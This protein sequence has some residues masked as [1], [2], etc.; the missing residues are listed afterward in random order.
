MPYLTRGNRVI[1]VIYVMLI[2]AARSAAA[3]DSTNVLVVVNELSPE[4]QEIASYYA[5]VR[6]IPAENVVRV[7]TAVADEIERRRY[8]LDIEVPILNHITSSSAHDR[9]LYLVLTKGIPLRVRGTTGLN[10]SVAS[11]DSEL[12]L[13]YQRLLGVRVLPAGRFPNPYFT[14]GDRPGQHVA[15]FSHE[16]HGIYL[17]TRLDGYTVADVKQ[18]IDRAAAPQ[19]EGLFVLDQ[20]SELRRSVGNTWLQQAAERLSAT[21][22]SKHV[23]FESTAAVAEV[24]KPVLGYFSWGSNDP[25]VKTRQSR[26]GFAP[27]ALAGTFV[28]TDARTF[29][30]PPANWAIGRW[31]DRSTFFE[32]SP[33]SLTGDLIRE[34]ATGVSGHVAEPYLDATV[35][36]HIL[37]PAYASGLNLA[38]SFYLGIPYLSWQNVVIGDPLCAPFRTKSLSTAEATPPLDPDTELP[39]YFS[40]KRIG[41][42][43]SLGVRS[44]VARLMLKASA[45]VARGDLGLATRSLEEVTELEPTLNAAHFVLATLY[46]RSGEYDRAIERY[47]MILSTAPEDVR[48]LNNLAYLIAVNKGTP[49]AALPLAEKAHAIAN[50]KNAQVDLDL[51]A[52]LIGRSGTPVGA[53]PFNIDAYDLSAMKAQISDT[54]GWIHYLIGNYA[55]AEPY[56]LEAGT[57]ARLSG[58]VQFHVASIHAALGRLDAAR[59]ALKQALALDSTLAENSQVKALEARLASK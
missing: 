41:V 46:D 25:A 5:K 57:G 44:Q 13:L 29:R 3:Q 18:L 30:E 21:G 40:A 51:G 59:A 10:G 34:G 20:R 16:K 47:R 11:V 49:T 48:S 52:S 31:T 1:A 4:S 38:E 2:A 23:V 50:A 27:G 43:E 36:P 37:F 45:Q 53:L 6:Q 26:M 35:R 24:Q 8:E 17:V 58:E 9:I 54:V 28:S 33:Q 22:L 32:G 12:T 56:I 7:R 19:R 39:R 42:L 14:D 55:Q 15:P